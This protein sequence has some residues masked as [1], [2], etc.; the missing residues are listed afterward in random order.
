[1]ANAI[2]LTG[3]ASASNRVRSTTLLARSISIPTKFPSLFNEDRE[4]HNE[5]NRE[6]EKQQD[7]D[8]AQEYADNLG[9]I[10]PPNESIQ[11]EIAR[12]RRK[13]IVPLQF[14]RSSGRV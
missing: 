6:D 4:E 1:M 8:K 7:T 9:K 14:E 11:R 12:L 10:E 2:E 13:S 3:K 5:N